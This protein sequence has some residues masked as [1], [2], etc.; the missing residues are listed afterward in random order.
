VS[1]DAQGLGFAI[2][3]SEAASLISEATGSPAS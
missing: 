2:P 1:T 3:I